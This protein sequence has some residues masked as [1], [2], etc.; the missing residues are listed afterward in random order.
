MKQRVAGN[1]GFSLL[2]VMVASTIS[3]I[4]LAA[5]LW[6]AAE[7]QRRGTLEESLMSA[8]NAMRAVRDLLVVDLQRAGTGAGS[9]RLVFGSR[10]SGAAD[11]R[12]AI[13][14]SAREPFDGTGLFPEDES[15]ALPT[16]PY[17]TRAS[18]AIQVWSWDTEAEDAAGH[19][20]PMLPLDT[21]P[22]PPPSPSLYRNGDTLCMLTN[23]AA[24]LDRLVLVVKPA[25]RTAC[26]MQVRAAN[27]VTS[28]PIP[29]WQ[30]SVTPGLPGN[31][32]PA[33]DLCS[34]P[35]AI[36]S[37]Q[38]T[39]FWQHDTAGAYIMPVR[40]VSFRINWKSGKPVLER[41]EQTSD[42]KPGL[43]TPPW[44]ALSQDVEQLR[45]RLGVKDNLAEL[46][47]EVLWFPDASVSPARPAIDSCDATCNALVPM[48]D[49]TPWTSSLD[50]PTARDALM[51]RLRMVELTVT[52]RT[53]RADPALARK[54]GSDFVLDADGNPQDGFKRRTATVEV[55]PRNYSYA[56]VIP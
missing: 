12:Y 11:V 5:A 52:T 17:A 3:L 24:L 46:D 39:N 27:E 18:D 40:G 26:I 41:H 56:G 15:F 33:G 6:S 2:E 49:G 16:G 29:Y 25:T 4:V 51:R 38:Y 7:L 42:V 54:S 43:P 32:P 34:A 36:P 55:M 1:G 22:T 10:P 28:A 48:P 47:A 50:E 35:P 21:C 23:P 37:T 13:T 30:V 9:A 53:S 20:I 44:V 19:A 8:Q 45:A 31:P 14:V